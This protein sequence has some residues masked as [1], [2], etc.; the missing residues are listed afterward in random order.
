[1]MIPLRTKSRGRVAAALRSAAPSSSGA[2]TIRSNAAAA[3]SFG[4]R[5]AAACFL[6]A[7]ASACSVG[8]ATS[9]ALIALQ[10]SV[11]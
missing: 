2:H 10:T 8:G 11:M 1:M 5:V 7:V 6:I 3:L 9:P 4:C